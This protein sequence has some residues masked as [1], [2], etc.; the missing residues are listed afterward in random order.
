MAR[1][2]EYAHNH[3]LIHRD[4]KPDNIMIDKRGTVKLADLGLARSQHDD[5]HLTQ[6]GAAV[7]T[8][9]YLAP[10]QAAGKT[11]LDPRADFYA[12]GATLYHMLTGET[13]YNGPSAAVIMARHL[14]ETPV[15]PDERR[16]DLEISPSTSAFVL[17]LMAREPAGRP[18]DA[19]EL[20]VETDDCIAA[21]GTGSAP[22]A[23]RRRR[24]T[25]NFPPVGEPTGRG[26]RR[27][28]GAVALPAGF[29]ETPPGDLSAARPRRRSTSIR[30][31]AGAGSP[32]P[33]AAAGI[34]VL[35]LGFLLF[36]SGGS[37]S[38]AGTS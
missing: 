9:H 28:T 13:P 21:C 4:V 24:S 10:E 12:L 2:L 14:T 5:A 18:R 6:S 11:D 7:G 38:P 26:R 16:A 20:L 25:G 34:V 15:P 32:M 30:S 35:I 29:D 33:Y 27:S 36:A 23:P 31:G 1:A 3:G 17:R 8:P 37:S 19:R 22:A